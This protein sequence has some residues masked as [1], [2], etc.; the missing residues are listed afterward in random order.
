MLFMS[1]ERMLAWFDSTVAVNNMGKCKRQGWID[2]EAGQS[3]GLKGLVTLRCSVNDI[4]SVT[5]TTSGGI[6]CLA[7]QI[8]VRGK[9]R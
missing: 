3:I 4:L 2:R 8:K 6:A 9:V 5:Y 7:H 1:T